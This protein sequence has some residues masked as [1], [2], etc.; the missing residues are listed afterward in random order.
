MLR[1]AEAHADYI[2]RR[3]ALVEEMA[4]FLLSQ[5]RKRLSFWRRLRLR[6]AAGAAAFLG[7]RE[8]KG[9]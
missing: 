9:V 7:I 5:R 1:Y 6:V 8:V 4:A 3:V 2:E